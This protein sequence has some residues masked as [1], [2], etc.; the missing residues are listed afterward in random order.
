MP[1][2]SLVD[3]NANQLQ[4]LHQREYQKQKVEGSVSSLMLFKGW[5]DAYTN[6]TDFPF[7]AYLEGGSTKAQHTIDNS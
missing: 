3:S 5:I 1:W 2:D 7:P 6:G 4:E